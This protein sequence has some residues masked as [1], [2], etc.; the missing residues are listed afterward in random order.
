[1]KGKTECSLISTLLT[2]QGMWHFVKDVCTVAR[3]YSYTATLVAELPE[4]FSRVTVVRVE[5]WYGTKNERL[6]K[7]FKPKQKQWSKTVVANKITTDGCEIPW[8]QSE[9][10]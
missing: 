9:V 1:M 4:V 8:K 5:T 2:C 7:K 3:G 10:Q 6:L